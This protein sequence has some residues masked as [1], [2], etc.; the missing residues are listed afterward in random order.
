MCV[1]FIS[2]KRTWK[3]THTFFLRGQL[4]KFGVEWKKCISQG[5]LRLLKVHNS[6]QT[7]RRT[8]WEQLCREVLEGCGGWKA[9]YELAVRACSP[10]GQLCPGL[11]QQSGQQVEEDCLPLLSPCEAWNA[12]F[13]PPAQEGCW[14]VRI[15]PEV[16]MKMIGKLEHL[17]YEER[18]KEMGLFS[19]EKAPEWPY[20]SFSIF[21]EG[22]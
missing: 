4:E 18:F 3:K 6:V 8:H 9:W 21:K 14:Y 19:L 10:E 20:G 16:A 15:G 2:N 7:G 17:S 5:I 12:T 22:L 13:R 1:S 11:H